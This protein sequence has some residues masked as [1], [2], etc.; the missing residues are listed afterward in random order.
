[1]S[2]KIAKILAKIA[3]T[4]EEYKNLHPKTKKTPDDPL[5]SKEKEKKKIK[6]DVPNNTK[7][8]KEESKQIKKTTKE[9]SDD[10]IVEKYK[11]TFSGGEFQRKMNFDELGKYA[12]KMSSDDLAY[13]LVNS[14]IPE[15][16]G[17]PFFQSANYKIG[18]F[19]GFMLQLFNPNVSKDERTSLA[20]YI[21]DKAG[22]SF[23]GGRTLNQF[24]TA[25]AKKGLIDK[26]LSEESEYDKL[27]TDLYYGNIS[28]SEEIRKYAKERDGKSMKWAYQLKTNPFTPSDVL[29]KIYQEHGSD[30]S[31]KE[32]LRHKN[33]P[34]ETLLKIRPPTSSD[35]YSFYLDRED[36]PS[37]IQQQIIE[38][39]I[40]K[41]NGFSIPKNFNFSEKQLSELWRK[42]LA[43]HKK[44]NKEKAQKSQDGFIYPTD[45]EYGLS[46]WAEHPNCPKEI[47]TE[48]LNWENKQDREGGVHFSISKAKV[49]AYQNLVKRNILKKEDIVN[50][51]KETLNL[52]GDEEILQKFGERAYC[53]ENQ[54]N[55][56]KRTITKVS[57]EEKLKIQEEMNKTAVH[58][59]FDYDVLE[60]YEID[61]EPHKDFENTEKR[62]NNVFKNVYH[63]TSFSNAGGI[64]ADGINTD[65]KARTGQ[66]FGQGFYL[67]SASS[68]AVQYAS[69]NF[70]KNEGEGVVFLLDASMGKTT[71][72]KYGRPA[73]DD[74][75]RVEWKDEIKKKKE[76]YEKNTGK[77][78]NTY[79]H[80]EHDSVIAKAGMSLDHDEYVVKD[81]S[82]LRIKRIVHVKKK[83][84]A[85]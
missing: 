13:H 82:Q 79:W 66:M 20:S 33:F 1:M 10:E 42:N 76:E 68:K 57:P 58:D 3:L 21:L 24:I 81:S 37:Q 4:Y 61:K 2:I 54:K 11:P 9:M 60:V 6:K 53:S 70:S 34:I 67:A 83:P 5:F 64:L 44:S 48:I 55:V 47:L 7:N 59:D 40:M 31:Y 19:N 25:L 22:V 77:T 56:V 36:V 23:V 51:V 26:S 63:G 12:E 8:K 14:P 84:K 35:N 71:E 43:S 65:S 17:H 80:L 16:E 32:V 62:I 45:T 85:G 46:K 41:G 74:I 49:S 52:H 72:M 27:R 29:V 78:T 15:D 73:N 69:D 39:Y 50:K 28:D 18:R 38:T 30:S 75:S